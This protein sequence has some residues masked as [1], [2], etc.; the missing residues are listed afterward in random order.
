MFTL[1][2]QAEMKRCDQQGFVLIPPTVVI[3]KGSMK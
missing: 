1:T 2:L 3:Y